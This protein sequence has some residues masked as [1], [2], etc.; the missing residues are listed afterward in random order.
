[1]STLI[2]PGYLPEPVRKLLNA[3]LGRQQTPPSVTVLTSGSGTYTTPAGALWLEVEMT[4]GG[5]GGAGSGTTPGVG[6]AGVDSTFGS[7][8]AH[9]AA[10]N[11]NSKTSGAAGTATGGDL[12]ITGQVGTYAEDGYTNAEGGTGGST[13]LG[14]GTSSHGGVQGVNGAGYG[15]GGGG[16]G[17]SGTASP[18]AGGSAAG[19]LRKTVASPAATYS[20]AVGAKG[21]GGIAGT[22]GFAGGDGAPGA[23]I[24]TAHY[25]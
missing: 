3:L 17:A 23:I 25:G 14:M 22:S 13:P 20:Y 16:A 15:A 7:L 5:A 19:Y 21:T 9:G 2:P 12:N 11:V 4:G 8:T 1:M 6:T 18:G 10:V 24:V